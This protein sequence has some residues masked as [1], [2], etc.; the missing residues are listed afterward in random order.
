[1]GMM[2]AIVTFQNGAW[3]ALGMM[4]TIVTFP[5]GTWYVRYDGYYCDVSKW[6]I[7]RSVGWILL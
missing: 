1:M 6:C 7:V 2:D 4:D 3:Y 5:N